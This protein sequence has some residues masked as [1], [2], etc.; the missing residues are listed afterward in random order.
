MICVR[1]LTSPPPH[2]TPITLFPSFWNETDL[3]LCSLRLEPAVWISPCRE[4]P[5]SCLEFPSAPSSVP[6]WIPSPVSLLSASAFARPGQPDSRTQ[7]C[8]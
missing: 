5:D 1:A 2:L 7:P 6:P 4:H 8:L 3:I